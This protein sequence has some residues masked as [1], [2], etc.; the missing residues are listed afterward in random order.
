M[1]GF[2]CVAVGLEVALCIGVV[3]DGFSQHAKIRQ[4]VCISVRSYFQRGLNS[5][6]KHKFSAYLCHGM[7][8]SATNDWNSQSFDGVA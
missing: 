3:A 8:H 6:P 2:Y 7:G 1:N 4:S 5:L